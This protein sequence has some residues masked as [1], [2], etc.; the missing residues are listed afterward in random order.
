[1]PTD[2]PSFL[3]DEPVRPGNAGEFDKI[4]AALSKAMPMRTLDGPITMAVYGPWG[5]GKT[6]F[7]RCLQHY[8]GQESANGDAARRAAVT[9]WFEPWRYEKERDLIIP[10][11]TELT[12]NLVSESTSQK[13]K[14]AILK[15]G[16]K[17]IGR[18]AKAA[19]RTGVDFVASQVGLKGSDIEQ[20]G[21]DFM[22]YYEGESERYTYPKSENQAFKEDFAHLVRMAATRG[23][24]LG[25]DHENA[26]PVAI[27]IDDLD[28]CSHEQVK[29]LLES[30]KNFL[31]VP[32]VTY[33]LAVDRE[34]VTLALSD[35]YR[36]SGP[37]SPEGALQAKAN[38]RNYLE[39]FFL[40]AFDIGDGAP[41]IVQGVVDTAK[42]RFLADLEAAIP[43]RS[44][45]DDWQNFRDIYAHGA[46]NLRRLKRIA[47][48]LYYELKIDPDR[49]SLQWYFA[50]YVFSE[51]YPV[52]WLDSLEGRSVPMRSTAYGKIVATIGLLER[53][54]DNIN[55]NSSDTTDVLDALRS[56]DPAS[57]VPSSNEAH[58]P[59]TLRDVVAP[60][61]GTQIGRYIADLIDGND[62]EELV[63]LYELAKNARNI[64][65]DY[66]L[67]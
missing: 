39:K 49:S 65:S 33:L 36:E 60:I 37:A 3:W 46:A 54:G 15:T 10:L 66:G 34:Q 56:L 45:P 5:S 6:T 26:R 29:R 52:V 1:M 16:L 43:A 25:L 27:F 51:N 47:R 32:G 48:W 55:L 17:L 50:E 57:T 8:L 13:V 61:A 40:Y 21:H 18:V 9:V 41:R 12:T 59:S 35:T 44:R 63:R 4:A 2:Q 58:I 64:G 53:F 24:S 22:S 28:R 7:L 67:S 38:A 31:W 19:A 20:I 42:A 30:M 23:T 14:Q 11:L 62:K